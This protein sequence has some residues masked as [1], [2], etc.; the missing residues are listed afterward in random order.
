MALPGAPAR[1][2][3]VGHV[4]ADSADVA[5]AVDLC[6]VIFLPRGSQSLRRSRGR[7]GSR[8]EKLSPVPL[9]TRNQATVFEGCDKYNARR[10]SESIWA[11]MIAQKHAENAD[12]FQPD[13]ICSQPFSRFGSIVKRVSVDSGIWGIRF[14]RILSSL[15]GHH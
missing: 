4:K 12:T 6:E 3:V 9:R 14:S 5:V 11:Q 2:P 8:R 10:T 7:Q 15:Y 1:F 13:K